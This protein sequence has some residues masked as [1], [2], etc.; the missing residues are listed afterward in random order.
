MTRTSFITHARKMTA[1]ESIDRTLPLS[2]C[3]A[4]HGCNFCQQ[5][6]MNYSLCC[7]SSTRDLFSQNNVVPLLEQH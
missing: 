6:F 7:P 5:E 4:N 2:K 1:R 3:S